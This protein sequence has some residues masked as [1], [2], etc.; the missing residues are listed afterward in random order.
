MVISCTPSSDPRADALAL[1]KIRQGWVVCGSFAILFTLRNIIPGL[2][3]LI[4]ILPYISLVSG[5]LNSVILKV[6]LFDKKMVLGLFLYIIAVIFSLLSLQYA[7]FFSYRDFLIISAVFITF[8]PVV[9]ISDKMIKTLFIVFV[10]NSLVGFTFKTNVSFNV[11]SY[12]VDSIAL[13]EDNAFQFA[14]FSLYFI[15]RKD[16]KWMTIS[17]FMNGIIFKRIAFFA[18]LASL[19]AYLY[20]FGFKPREY[21]N[22]QRYRKS[23]FTAVIYVIILYLIAMNIAYLARIILNYFHYYDVSAD[24]F[25]Q[26]RIAI[27]SEL[28]R[29]VSN[30]EIFSTLFGHGIGSADNTLQVIYLIFDNPHNDFLKLQFEYGIIG[31]LLYILAIWTIIIRNCFSVLVFIFSMT[32]LPTDN[33]IIYITYQILTMMLVKSVDYKHTLHSSQE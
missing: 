32:L 19:G 18:L 21:L 23:L 13:Q 3:Q 2:Q 20:L 7:T 14:L 12:L 15:Y 8:I 10:I 1:L 22:T 26:G 29:I 5:I 11:R 9:A 25:L 17:L 4:Y 28:N 6:I 27:Q 16:Y 24:Y 30:T 31:L 33:T